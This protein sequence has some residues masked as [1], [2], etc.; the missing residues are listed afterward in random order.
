MLGPDSF[1]ARLW[2]QLAENRMERDRLALREIEVAEAIEAGRRALSRGRLSEA[3]EALE[4]A[5][6]LDPEHPGVADLKSRLWLAR[7]PK[8]EP[9]PDIDELAAR[10]PPPRRIEAQV[11]PLERPT[12][13][14]T[15]TVE[16]DF[17][18]SLPRGVLTIYDG[19]RQIFK[20]A[21]RF[22]ERRRLLPPKAATGSLSG[23]MDMPAGEMSWRVYLSI[24]GS[25]TQVLPV[26]GTL[27][28]GARHVL[29]LR[30]SPEGRF[31]ADLR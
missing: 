20:E 25:E 8:P 28:G 26:E 17:F 27:R 6:L 18:S 3:D 16:I 4:R 22:Y 29:N 7:Q 12:V 15:A 2:R 10:P 23:R 11:I 30:V 14:T 5:T 1:R 31:T 13:S 24:P 19:E 9:K 21:F